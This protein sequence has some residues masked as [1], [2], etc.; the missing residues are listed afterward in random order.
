MNAA[1]LHLILNHVPVVLAAFTPL[2]LAWVLVRGSNESRRLGMGVAVLLGLTA[3]PAFISG[4]PAGE[5]AEDVPGISAGLIEP[6][7]EAAEAAL[8]GVI[9][10]GAVALAGL[11]YF[12]R[13]AMVP[14]AL[15]AVLLVGSVVCAG[16]MTW[17]ANL[18]GKIH[19][20]EITA[21]SAGGHH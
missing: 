14:S 10:L 5:I 11:L 13:A 1:H 21:D 15:I 8:I 3:L 16:L 18:G 19:H 12:R 9:V 20:S 7:E 6:H 17:T 4:E 2:F